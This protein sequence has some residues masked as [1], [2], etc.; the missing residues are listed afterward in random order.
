MTWPWIKRIL[1]TA[2]AGALLVWT[3]R[4]IF[5]TDEDRIQQQIS[6]MKRAIEFG[7][8]VSLSNDI[9]ADYSDNLGFDKRTVLGFIHSMR[10]Q[11]DAV[12]IRIS[13]LDVTVAPDRATARVN[14]RVQAL[15]ANANRIAQAELCDD[16]YQ[17]DFRRDGRAWKLFRADKIE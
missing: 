13:E 4:Q 7:K 3:I 6:R 1:I 17:L 10:R 8:I 16:R 14:L 2:I 5:V 9:A 15:S 12:L 11:Y